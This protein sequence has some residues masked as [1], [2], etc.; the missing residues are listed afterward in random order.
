MPKTQASNNVFQFKV[1]LNYSSPPIWRRL[2]IPANYTFFELHCA[3]QDAMDWLSYHLH[4]FNFGK[5]DHEI[6]LSLPNPDMDNWGIPSRD[7]SKEVIGDYFGKIANQC[8]YTYDFGDSWDHTILLERVLSKDPK[9]DY[10]QCIAGKN[11]CPPEDCGGIPGYEYLKEILNNPKHP[12]HKETLEWLC[13]DSATEFDSTEFD[14]G[15]V[16]FTDPIAELKCWRKEI[17]QR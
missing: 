10:P 15:Q 12:E 14:P 17:K 5:A 13:I 16:E 2:L 6:H 7:E 4:G 1:T 9:M 11:A 3:I 8:V